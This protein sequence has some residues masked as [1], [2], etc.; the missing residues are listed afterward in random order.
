M[1][2]KGIIL[3]IL[4]SS[5]VRDAFCQDALAEAMQT[6]KKAN[7]FQVVFLI[8]VIGDILEQGVKSEKDG[9]FKYRFEYFDV[10]VF[11]NTNVPYSSM[12]SDKSV[13]YILSDSRMKNVFI[14]LSFYHSGKLVQQIRNN[15]GVIYEVL[16]DG[17]QAKYVVNDISVGGIFEMQRQIGN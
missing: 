14:V 6:A 3:L 13:S 8:Q 2:I 10:D 11:D 16:I 7:E 1:E 5:L 12:G 9:I 17:D 4:F 15:Q